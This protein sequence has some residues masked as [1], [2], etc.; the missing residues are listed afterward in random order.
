MEPMFE[1]LAEQLMKDVSN[2]VAFSLQLDEYA[3]IRDAAH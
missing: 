2:C 3:D 1:N